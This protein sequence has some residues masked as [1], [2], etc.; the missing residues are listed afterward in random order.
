[1]LEIL[2]VANLGVLQGGKVDCLLHLKSK[3]LTEDCCAKELKSGTDTNTLGSGQELEKNRACRNLQK[4][5]FD[6]FACGLSVVYSC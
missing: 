2:C 5:Y 3:A 1:M 6:N 4:C